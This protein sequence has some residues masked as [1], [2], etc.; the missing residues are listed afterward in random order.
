MT[1]DKFDAPILIIGGGPIG[2]A[3]ALDLAWRGQRS[4]LIERDSGT[5][6]VMLAKANGLHER[7][8]ETC[9]RW[10]LVENIKTVGFPPDLPGDSVYCTSVTGHLIGRTIMG[11]TNSRP[12]PEQTPEKRQRCAQYEFDPLLANAV[13]SYGLTEIRYSTEFLSMQQD[14]T[15][16]SVHLGDLANGRDYVLRSCFLV[17]CEGAASRVRRQLEIPFEGKTLDFSLSAMVRMPDLTAYG[18]IENAERFIFIGTEGAWGNLTAVDG[19]GIWRFT[20]LGSQAKLDAAHYDI[21][22]D[23]RRALGSDN[24]EF[25]IVRLLPWR[26]SQCVA[27]TYR[28][29]R[30]LLAGDSA[31]TTSPTGGHGM[32]T[33]VADAV[34]LSWMLD[35]ILNGW[36]DEGLLSA[37]DLERRPV[38]IRNSLN[39][40]HNYRAWVQSEG[41]QDVF[42][43]G[44][45]GVDCRAA[46][47]RRLEQTLHGEWHSLGI[48][49]GYRYEQSP[50]IIPDGT[51]ATADDITNYIPTARPGHRAPHA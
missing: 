44:R 12:L 14:E 50:I 30:V 49:L 2:L 24:L 37:Y 35:A 27:A 17:S 23:I 26:R 33:G 42:D 8:M 18:A 21:R 41:Y 7:T 19:R 40:A 38:G 15:G 3:L 29:G 36:G 6:T 13:K 5:A 31:H 32:N 25:E 10:G 46:I 45:R 43:D 11:S 48:E 51:T 34:D 4:T 20:I 16:V 22:P 39:S 9:R 1:T 47:G 28:V